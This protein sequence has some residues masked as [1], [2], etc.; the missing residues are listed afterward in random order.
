MTTNKKLTIHELDGAVLHYDD[1]MKYFPTRKEFLDPDLVNT[2]QTRINSKQKLR[3]RSDHLYEK[4]LLI[5]NGEYDTCKFSKRY[6]CII[7]TGVLEDG[8]S[9]IVVINGIRPYFEI[10]VPKEY[11]NDEINEMLSE[12]RKYFDDKSTNYESIELIEGRD[13]PGG[14]GYACKYIKCSFNT[15]TGRKWALKDIIETQHNW[16]TRHDDQSCY[17]RV[18]LRDLNLPIAGWCDILKYTI[19]SNSN[20]PFIRAKTIIM[21]DYN[22]IKTCMDDPTSDPIL[23]LNP[24]IGVYWDGEMGSETGQLPDPLNLNDDLFMISMNYISHQS[25]IFPIA[26]D[27]ITDIASN[28]YTYPKPRGHYIN[29]CFTTVPV[30]KMPNRCIIYCRNESQMI[31]S[32]FTVWGKM[33]PN[34]D[35]TFNGFNFDWNWLYTR[36]NHLKLLPFIE[37]TMS[38]IDYDQY[39]KYIEKFKIY[40]HSAYHLK[41]FKFKI[42]ATLTVTG[43]YLQFPGCISIDTKPQLRRYFGNPEKNSLNS[44]LKIAKLGQKADMPIKIMFVIYRAMKEFKSTYLITHDLNLYGYDND[45]II[46]CFKIADREDLAIRYSNLLFAMMLIAEYCFIDGIKCNDLFVTTNFLMDKRA[47]GIEGFISME[48]A[49]NRADGMKVTNLIYNTCFEYNYHTTSRMGK[50]I[51]FKYPGARVFEPIRKEIKPRLNIQERI[52]RALDGDTQY[53]DWLEY[54]TPELIKGF[55]NWIEKNDAWIGYML[56]DMN[57]YDNNQNNLDS[58]KWLELFTNKEQA[59]ELFNMPKCFIEL[60]IENPETGESALDFNSLYPS[61]IMELN[62]SLENKISKVT[63]ALQYKKDGIPINTIDLCLN[64][65]LKIKSWM[66]HHEMKELTDSQEHFGIYPRILRRLFVNRKKIRKDMEPIDERLEHIENIIL[67]KKNIFSKKLKK[68][69]HH[70]FDIQEYRKN[71]IRKKEDFSQIWD[72]WDEYELKTYIQTTIV[73]IEKEKAKIAAEL[74]K[75]KDEDRQLE[76]L[77][78]ELDDLINKHNY[79]DAKQ[80]ALKVFMNTFYGKAGESISPL[81]DLSVAAG[82]TLRGR[83]LLVLLSKWLVDFKKSKRLY[84]DTDSCYFMFNQVYF[85]NIH[86][87]Y[88]SG[89][90]T[91]LTYMRKIINVCIVLSKEY[92]SEVNDYFAK[93]TGGPFIKVAWEEV[94]YPSIHMGKKK[95]VMIPHES[96]YPVGMTDE[97]FLIKFKSIKLFVRGIE[98]KKKGNSQLLEDIGRDVWKRSFDPFCTDT[99]F[100]TVTK[101]LEEVYTAANYNDSDFIKTAAYKPLSEQL[102]AQG[103]GNP[104]VNLFVSRMKQ[105]NLEPEPFERFYYVMVQ[106]YPYEYDIKGRKRA[107]KVGERMEYPARAKEL[108]LKIDIDYYMEGKIKAELARYIRYH[109]SLYVYPKNVEDDAECLICDEKSIDKAKKYIDNIC[110]KFSVKWVD[111]GLI[112]KMLYKE[113]NK[114]IAPYLERIG[115][116][117]KLSSFNNDTVEHTKIINKS[118]FDKTI[119]SKKSNDEIFERFVSMADKQAIKEAEKNANNIVNNMNNTKGILHI[120]SKK[121]SDLEIDNASIK[122]SKVLFNNEKIHTKDEQFDKLVSIIKTYEYLHEMRYS[123]YEVVKTHIHIDARKHMNLFRKVLDNR[124]NLIQNTIDKLFNYYQTQIDTDDDIVDYLG[125]IKNNI[126]YDIAKFLPD[127]L[128]DIQTKNLQID[129]INDLYI[130]LFIYSRSYYESKYVLELLQKKKKS[131]LGIFT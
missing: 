128:E 113:T 58:S 30:K 39:N 47:Q 53:L 84:G 24:G 130:K 95:Y 13:F 40:P 108:G 49:I 127:E 17:Y 105:Y 86:K 114:H 119:M 55:E 38:V 93:V 54:N 25:K 102:I 59:L 110:A 44:Y 125:S 107:L 60:I 124:D 75:P 82:T 34:F 101:K 10:R 18:V 106:R 9:Q 87:A 131:L 121:K 70:N 27:P 91:K 76:D 94:G 123:I 112:H 43:E 78:Q 29:V 2:V 83:E 21:V 19:E 99:L 100:E 1:V 77:E 56:I 63:D 5:K 120:T 48:D 126:S 46:E 20:I 111:N 14:Y 71:L 16:V 35:I 85:R 115:W 64:N 52:Q 90:I 12:V 97:E 66:R 98:I 129:I 22:D 118:A 32:I 28:S 72:E 8:R 88:Y 73:N 117:S 15:E 6:Y 4:Y 116:N 11:T 68:A 7:L 65:Q 92:E 74:N 79:L 122:Y 104:T 3:F 41:K 62:L 109:P 96:I 26:A 50:K 45:F 51:D 36:A 57:S 69:N 81:F 23:K 42:D 61:I 37:Q 67:N 103:K 89:K 80:K 31:M 33:R